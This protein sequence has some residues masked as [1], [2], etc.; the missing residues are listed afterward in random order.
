MT[1]PRWPRPHWPVG[2]LMLPFFIALAVASVAF[3]RVALKILVAVAMFL[4]VSGVVMIIQD[5]HHLR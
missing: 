2:N 3:W 4:V 1:V 5:L